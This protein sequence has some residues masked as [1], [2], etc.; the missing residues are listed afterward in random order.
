MTEQRSSPILGY[1]LANG[2]IGVVELMRNRSQTIWSLDPIQM[3]GGECAP[4]S[5]VKMCRL[6]KKAA[7]MQYGGNEV[8]FDF[9]IARDDGRIEIYNF[10]MT[11]AFPTLCYECQIKSTITGLDIGNVTMAT[12]KDVMVSCYDGQIL[13]LIDTKKFKQQGI[14]GSELVMTQAD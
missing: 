4:V 6:D 12:S 11:S 7:V 13:S 8:V 10:T 3:Q 2:G 1:G 5:L 14:M 9:V